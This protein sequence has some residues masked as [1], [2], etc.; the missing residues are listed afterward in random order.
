MADQRHGL[1][2]YWGLL[3]GYGAV[4]FVLGI[5]VA[6]WPDETLVVVAVLIAIQLLVTGVVRVV[7]ALA[8]GPQDAGV[9]VLTGLI[10]ALALVVGLLCLRD[11]LQTL[12]AI[13][14]LLGAWW[15]VSGVFDIVQAILPRTANRGW[16]VLG[17]V[18]SVL[19]GGFLLV[20]PDISLGLLVLVLAVWLLVVGALAMVA[21]VRLRS[22]ARTAV[23]PEPA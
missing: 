19:A 10:G 4:T 22:A 21:A 20:N 5:V 14:L 8:P 18:V 6:V 7:L 2:A 16:E 1:A 3:L 11:P 9:R 12:V 17:G 15:V 13:T 23:A